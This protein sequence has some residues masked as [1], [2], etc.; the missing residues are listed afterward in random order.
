MILGR[1]ISLF[2]GSK[3]I[4]H[5]VD[6]EVR[7]GT[8]VALCGPNG[9]G[10]STLLSALAGDA[11]LSGGQVTYDG[12][13]CEDLSAK[14]LAQK[15]AV[16]EQSPS[17][18][19]RFT[20][21][22]L[23]RLSIPLELTPAETDTVVNEGLSQL[24]LLP[25]QKKLVENLSGGQR[26]RAHFARVLAQLRANRRLF[27]PN[28]LLLDEP[29]ASLDIMHQIEVMK[30]AKCEAK[31]GSG[32]LVVLHDLNLAAAFADHIVLMGDGKVLEAGC[33]GE[34][35]QSKILSQVYGTS[36]VVEKS[37]SAPLHIRPNFESIL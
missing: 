5:N 19:A 25:F 36:I 26:H 4:L 34:V 15:R 3:K 35:F 14:E 7:F 27:G 24:G 1:R 13:F 29:T 23:V 32:V 33:T 17:L 37:G 16:L 18:T 21:D 11:K 28:H 8:V 22:E 9:A 31:K 6:V 10:K 12:E 2:Y 30:A 20:V